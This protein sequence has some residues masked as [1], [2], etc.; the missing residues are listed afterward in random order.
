MSVE[1]VF[2]AD[3]ALPLYRREMVE[4]IMQGEDFFDP[5]FFTHKEDWD[6]AWRARWRGWK[7]ILDPTCVAIHPRAF[8]PESL[9]VRSA[10]SPEIR[11]HALKNQMILLLKNVDL[12]TFIMRFPVIVLRQLSIF[13]FVMV[14]ERESLSAYI[15]VAQHFRGIVSARRRN[16]LQR[17]VSP[18]EMRKFLSGDFA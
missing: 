4:D 9:K 15:F 1:E 13:M 2:G 12:L 6:V 10:M 18:N 14:C 7:T 11:Y 17:K 8:K 5:M 3:G 16:R